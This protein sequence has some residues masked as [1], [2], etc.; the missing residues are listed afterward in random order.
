MSLSRSTMRWWLL[1]LVPVALFFSW[2]WFTA[3]PPAPPLLHLPEDRLFHPDLVIQ[4]RSLSQLPKDILAIPLLNKLLTE[5]F[6]FYYERNENRLSLEGTA[7]RIAY[8]HNIGV[9][10]EILAYALNTPA[11]IAFWK[12]K[13]GKLKDFLLILPKKGLLRFVEAAARIALD[14]TQL[15]KADDVRLDKGGEYTVWRVQHQVVK[16]RV[17][18]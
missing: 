15:A 7:R 9:G 13:D 2:Q 1:A 17:L 10:D 3:P 4:S 14:D 5:E 11:Q 8:E 6:V 12:N 16:R 18:F